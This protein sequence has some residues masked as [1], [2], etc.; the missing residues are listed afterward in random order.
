MDSPN[1]NDNNSIN[2]IN[3]INSDKKN[4]M[5]MINV[6][7]PSPSSNPSTP[8]I[9]LS[10]KSIKAIPNR[11]INDNNNNADNSYII[12]SPGSPKSVKVIPS[13]PIIKNNNDNNNSSS[14]NRMTCI[15]GSAPI[16]SIKTRKSYLFK[17]KPINE[18]IFVKKQYILED[19]KDDGVK[20]N[21]N[22]EFKCSGEV[23]EPKSKNLIINKIDSPIKKTHV[24]W[25]ADFEN[26]I[27]SFIY[28]SLQYSAY[29]EE[30]DRIKKDRSRKRTEE[31]LLFEKLDK[32]KVENENHEFIPSN[33]K[34]KATVVTVDNVKPINS[35]NK[36]DILEDIDIKGEDNLRFAIKEAHYLK[37]QRDKRKAKEARDKALGI[38]ESKKIFNEEKNK[39]SNLI[40]S[41]AFKRKLSVALQESDPT[42]I[43]TA[44]YIE[45]HGDAEKIRQRKIRYALDFKKERANVLYYNS[46]KSS[47]TEMIDPSFSYESEGLIYY[48]VKKQIN[49][50]KLDS[51]TQISTNTT[52]NLPPLET[53]SRKHSPVSKKREQK[54]LEHDV[55]TV[56]MF[57]S[58]PL[59]SSGPSQWE[60]MVL[61]PGNDDDYYYYY[62]FYYYYYHYYRLFNEN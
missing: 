9:R 14:N 15:L 47:V 50:N 8:T 35:T 28:P 22:Y 6:D 26:R 27:E 11:I 17:S 30:Q 1:Q 53:V 3:S 23:I 24:E 18:E 5:S 48:G 57:D 39:L 38:V 42:H 61:N 52:L 60:A 31:E 21:Y 62:Y 46:A 55:S 33:E 49:D 12:Y 32:K 40:D 44:V 29:L 45:A 34:W 2:S 7:I 43:A 10:R 4:R 13:S 54:K 19:K 56:T 16:G 37:K 20:P 51:V 41:D 58:N 36:H 25:K 59:N